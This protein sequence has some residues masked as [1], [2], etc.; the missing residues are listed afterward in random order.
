M[1]KKIITIAAILIL[2]SPFAWAWADDCA[3]TTDD[4]PRGEL[5]LIESSALGLIIATHFTNYI[6]DH[7]NAFGFQLNAGDGE[8]RLG[9][10]WAHLFSATQ[11]FKITAEHLAQNFNFN[12]FVDPDHQTVG[13]NEFSGLYQ[14]LF[15]NQTALRSF[16]LGGYYANAETEN[17]NTIIF[18]GP[19]N[20]IDVQRIAGASSA[21]VVSGF[22][23]QPMVD[24]RAEIDLNYDNVHYPTQYEP[25]RDRSGLGATLTLQQL[26]TGHFRATALASYR[27]PFH[28]YGVGLFWLASTRPGTRLE[29][30][31]QGSHLDG[32]Y[33]LGTDN[34]ITLGLTYSWG[35]NP[36][37]P[38]ANYFNENFDSLIN[39]AS[40]PV[41]PMP[42]VLVQ[43]DEAVLIKPV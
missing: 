39:W 30:G 29:L 34:R 28:Q 8:F 17:V 31:L 14:Y 25:A 10:T 36:D 26:F 22:G 11:R 38:R 40:Q 16:N 6:Y 3:T 13:Q 33:Y 32:S 23:F 24:T 21:G 4:L 1:L 19:I 35:G 37:M 18:N 43:K 2:S 20:L 15:A 7:A 41:L 27:N 5:S 12:Y 9:G 42:T